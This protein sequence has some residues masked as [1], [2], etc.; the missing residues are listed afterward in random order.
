MKWPSHLP[1]INPREHLWVRQR[2]TPPWSK[3]RKEKIYFGRTVARLSSRDVKN[4]FQGA[5]KLLWQ[6][7]TAAVAFCLIWYVRAAAAD[8]STRIS[9]TSCGGGLLLYRSVDQDYSITTLI[10]KPGNV[11]RPDIISNVFKNE[12]PEAVS[13]S[14]T[15]RWL[16][17]FCLGIP[18]LKTDFW[19]FMHFIRSVTGG[20]Q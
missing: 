12:C 15:S 5:L 10:L 1:D 8:I 14:T 4:Q 6:C 2:C 16:S 9:S 19:C 18:F 17:R 3:E 11:D 13:S 20:R 7:L